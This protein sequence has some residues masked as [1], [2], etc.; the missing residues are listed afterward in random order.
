M[1]KGEVSEHAD[2]EKTDQVSDFED[3]QPDGLGAEGI[4]VTPDSDSLRRFLAINRS[5]LVT[6]QEKDSTLQELKTHA[7]NGVSRRNVSFPKREGILY[8]N[9]RDRKVVEFDQ[10]VVPIAYRRDLLHLAHGSSWS[11]HLRLKKT[12]DRLLQEY[13]WPGCF[14]QVEQFV[15]WYDSCQRIGKPHDKWKAP[16]K[17][18]PIITNMFR[19]LAIDTVGPLPET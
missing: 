14:R 15:R 16:V 7:K 13:Y 2:E 4:C 8:R 19:R 10:L 12:K 5:T 3:S 1:G 18:V 6:E 11:G 9:Y 17:F